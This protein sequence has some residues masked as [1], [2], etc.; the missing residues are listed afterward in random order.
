[1]IMIMVLVILIPRR[2]D[3]RLMNWA[4]L[5]KLGGEEEMVIEKVGW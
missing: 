5:E 3:M 1:V 2:R 4:L